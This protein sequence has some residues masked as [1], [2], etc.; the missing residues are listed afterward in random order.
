MFFKCSEWLTN[1][2]LY[3]FY[4]CYFR[5][6]T[7]ARESGMNDAMAEP[8]KQQAPSSGSGGGGDVVASLSSSNSTSSNKSSPA[9]TFNKILS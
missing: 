6:I 3:Y 9:G 5:A 2:I 4:V 8:A 1:N 7:R